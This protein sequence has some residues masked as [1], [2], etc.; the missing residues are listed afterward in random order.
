MRRLLAFF[1]RYKVAYRRK[2]VR[3]N[4]QRVFPNQSPSQRN[5]IEGDFY[6]Y[7]GGLIWDL[8]RSLGWSNQRLKGPIELVNPELL[9]QI[10]HDGHSVVLLTSHYGNW[11]WIARRL[12][13]LGAFHFWFVYKPVGWARVEHW[14]R[15]WRKRQGLVPIPIKGV[16]TQLAQAFQDGRPAHPLALYLGADQTPT[17]HSRW[18]V[19]DFLGQRS[20]MYQGPE[21]L[22]RTYPLIPVFVGIEPL[23]QGSY[24]I[25]LEEAPSNWIL[26][27]HGYLMQWYLDR[28][29]QQINR[30]P[31]YWLWTHRRWK[32]DQLANQT[33][34]S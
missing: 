2:V 16:R 23:E 4:L 30:H 22:C 15:Q 5:K 27:P 18:I 21:E 17:A 24:R 33:K 9:E 14:L 13:S 32:H 28:L 19:G 12:A 11:E 25:R 29:T 31:S 8:L 7:L 6:R 26:Q 3:S 10:G 34:V 1:L 20:L